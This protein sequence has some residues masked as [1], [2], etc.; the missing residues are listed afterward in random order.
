MDKEMAK[1]M[2]QSEIVAEGLAMA[3]KAITE[4]DGGIPLPDGVEM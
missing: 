1:T 4:N 2:T 3:L